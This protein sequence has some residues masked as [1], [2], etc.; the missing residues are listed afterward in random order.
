MHISAS[1]TLT[2]LSRHDAGVYS[3][4]VANASDEVLVVTV[5][6][7]SKI[8]LVCCVQEL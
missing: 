1:L 7:G 2:N 8:L 4:T 5:K 6:Q 3:C